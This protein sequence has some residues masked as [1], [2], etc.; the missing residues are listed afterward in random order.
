MFTTKEKTLK[1]VD[2]QIDR[3]AIVV[4]RWNDS[5]TKSLLEGARN[6]LN[7]I[8]I[9]NSSIDV[10]WVSGSFELPQVCEQLAATKRFDAIVPIGCLIRG[11]TIHDQ[12][13][14]NATAAGLEAVGRNHPHCGVSFGILTV[15]NYDQALA[16]AGGRLG[17]KGEDAALAAVELA[18]IKKELARHAESKSRS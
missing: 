15:N 16:R 9:S 1:N 17:N 3:V 12:V 13:I 10:F 14:A 11:E 4:G 8:G 2:G 7:G 5:I 18:L 6:A